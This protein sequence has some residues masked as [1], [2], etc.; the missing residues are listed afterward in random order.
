MIARVEIKDKWVIKGIFGDGLKKL[1]GLDDFP[2]QK[3]ADISDEILIND[4]TASLFRTE[5]D[6][7]RFAG[8][9]QKINKPMIFGGGIQK[10]RDIEN[11]LTAGFDRVLICS[12][13]FD[14]ELGKQFIKEAAKQFGVSTIIVGF[15]ITCEES[16]FNIH[17]SHPRYSR[18]RLTSLETIKRWIEN[19][20]LIDE[21]EIAIFDLSNEGTSKG[22]SLNTIRSITNITKRP[23][24]YG[25]GGNEQDL[26]LGGEIFGQD[27]NLRTLIYCAT[28]L[29]M[30][31]FNLDEMSY[32][33]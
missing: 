4:V 32:D 26:R 3:L 7:E 33:R 11:A 29:R 10:L 12:K 9:R 1:S 27:K 31:G 8:I 20:E 6:F 5:L 19:I 21:F 2:W 16:S 30:L 13:S 23:V 28:V 14:G 22:F 18:G 15:E 25:G 17:T 24:I